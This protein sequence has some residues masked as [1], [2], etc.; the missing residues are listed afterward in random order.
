[1]H[2]FGLRLLQHWTPAMPAALK[3]YKFAG[4]MAQLRA[5]AHKSGELRHRDGKAYR[6]QDMAKW[7]GLREPDMR[8]MLQAGVLAGIVVV[9]GES[10]RGKS[11]L[12]MLV[13]CPFP[14]W[15]A[16]LVYLKGTAR[17]PK[18]DEGDAPAGS[19]DH[20]GSNSEFGPQWP[21]LPQGT[22]EEVRTTVARPSSDHSGTTGSD[23]GGPN[24]TGGSQENNREMADVVGQQPL[25]ASEAHGQTDLISRQRKNEPVAGGLGTGAAGAAPAEQATAVRVCA[26]GKGRIVRAD[27]DRCGGCLRDEREAESRAEQERRRAEQLRRDNESAALVLGGD[28]PASAPAA[29][30]PAAPA[31]PVDP[32]ADLPLWGPSGELIEP[33]EYPGWEPQD[34]AQRPALTS[35]RGEGRPARPA[36]GQVPGQR[37]LLGLLAGGLAEGEQTCVGCGGTYRPADEHDYCCQRCRYG[38]SDAAVTG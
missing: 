20:S 16:A 1:M 33:D 8:R 15:E 23:H 24:N 7:C 28:K 29:P 30:A 3:K 35:V 26:C 6:I 37:P 25:R 13:L 18:D 4:V 22:P 11:T 9:I 14:N 5:V 10:K 38:T 31:T 36:K 21:E 17:T 27:R 2:T 12:Y 19:S 32:E 34:D